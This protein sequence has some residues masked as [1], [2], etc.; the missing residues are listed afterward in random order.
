MVPNMA[1]DQD[2]LFLAGYHEHCWL[3]TPRNDI[4]SRSSSQSASGVPCSVRCYCQPSNVLLCHPKFM[5]DPEFMWYIW[6]R[7]T[8]LV[9]CQVLSSGKTQ[10]NTDLELNPKVLPSG[11]DDFPR[12]LI[13]Q[14]KNIT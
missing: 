2:H 10:C 7:S 1:M 5:N 6:I 9:L 8:K 3:D 14:I 4:G 11:L 13:L 12:A